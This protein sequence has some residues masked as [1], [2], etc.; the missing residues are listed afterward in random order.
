MNDPRALVAICER[1]VKLPEL[2]PSADKKVTHCNQF[3]DRALHEWL[4]ASPFGSEF[5]GLMANAIVDKLEADH[6]WNCYEADEYAEYAPLVAAGCPAVAGLKEAG[7][8]HVNLVIVGQ[9]VAAGH[10]D[11]AAVPPCAN[12][13]K[14]NWVGKGLNYAF[15]AKPRIWI[16]REG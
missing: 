9:P 6:A 4:G 3:V 1:L 2:Q 5:H 14:Q 13:G 7:H 12:V 16:L 10:W 15:A 8:G 11:L